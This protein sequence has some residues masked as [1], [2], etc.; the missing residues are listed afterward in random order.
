LAAVVLSRR[1]C[2]GHLDGAAI[3]LFVVEVGDRLLSR[4]VVGH[5]HKGKALRAARRAVSDQSYGR[6]LADACKQLAQ[7]GLG[8]VV[9]QIPYLQ[10]LRHFFILL[11]G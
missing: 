6:D 8:G 7:G 5:F 2:F 4:G 11:M 1:A 3:H 10:F 9:A